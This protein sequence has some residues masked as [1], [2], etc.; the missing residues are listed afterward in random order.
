MLPAAGAGSFAQEPGRLARCRPPCSCNHLTPSWASDGYCSVR[1]CACFPPAPRCTT[2]LSRSCARA[3]GD[4]QA[5]R[6]LRI[7]VLPLELPPAVF[8]SL[9]PFRT[10]RPHRGPTTILNP[11]LTHCGHV[12]AMCRQLPPS[13]LQHCGP[14]SHPTPTLQSQTPSQAATSLSHGTSR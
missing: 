3:T 5:A 1:R 11:S 2:P 7:V 8:Q 9:A 13:L 4:E 14:R 10:L 6:H 12:A